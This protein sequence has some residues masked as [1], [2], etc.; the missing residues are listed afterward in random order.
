M[1]CTFAEAERQASA[2]DTRARGAGGYRPFEITRAARL[3]NTFPSH[4][5]SLPL[6]D[7]FQV[8][9]VKNRDALGPVRPSTGAKFNM[10][11]Q[12]P[13]EAEEGHRNRALAQLESAVCNRAVFARFA[14][15]AKSSTLGVRPV[16]VASAARVCTAGA[17]H[18][19]GFCQ[20]EKCMADMGLYSGESHR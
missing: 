12:A 18:S 4:F 9:H 13:G 5:A 8:M 16:Q 6:G 3:R 1:A 11:V 15:M 14:C 20:F 10:R 19:M 2:G 7:V 17:D